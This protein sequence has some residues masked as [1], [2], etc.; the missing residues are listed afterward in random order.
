[1][2]TPYT[3]K[4]VE[5]QVHG[6]LADFLHHGR[7]DALDEVDQEAATSFLKV[8]LD[9]AH[10]ELGT[11]PEDLNAEQLE[12]ILLRHMP[13]RIAAKRRGADQAVAVVSAYFED[14][15]TRQAKSISAE[16][17][18]VLSDAAKKF[19]GLL[20][21]SDPAEEVAAMEPL[22]REES[23]VGRNDPCPCGSG[24]KY[25]KCHGTS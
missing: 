24:K 2:Q 1:M 16:Q 9:V 17:K 8:F 10:R 20:S 13:R 25:K 18:K 15:E 7:W 12:E 22:R 19:P 6:A 4:Q 11:A 5:R 23:K 14:L 21:G 3:E